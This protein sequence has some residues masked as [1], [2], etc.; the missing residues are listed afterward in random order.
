M[1]RVM[2][3]VGRPLPTQDSSEARGR[4]GT[5][6]W[7]SYLIFA[8]MLLLLIAFDAQA[9]YQHQWARFA[10]YLVFTLLLL[11][12]PTGGVKWVRRRVSARKSS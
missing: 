10:A 11:V 5:G 4:R 9:S 2:S 3:G 6:V 1:L 8:L 7:V 12:V